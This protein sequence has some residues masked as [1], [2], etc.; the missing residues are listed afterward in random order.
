[1][2]YLLTILLVLLTIT[3]PACTDKKNKETN[4]EVAP[5]KLVEIKDG[6]SLIRQRC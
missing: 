4:K 2:K 6:Q 3:L 1:M 5:E